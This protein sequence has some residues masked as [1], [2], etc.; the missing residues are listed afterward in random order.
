MATKEE[1]NA[2]LEGIR[3]QTGLD[4]MVP[5]GFGMVNLHVQDEYDAHL[6]FI[7]KTGKILC[8]V[9]LMALTKDAGKEV[10][11]DL[12]AGGLFGVDTAG[13]YFSLETASE[14]V[15]YNY[16]FDFDKVA[17]S[18]EVFIETFENIIALMD[19]WK[20]RIQ[21]KLTSQGDSSG[22]LLSDNSF[23]AGGNG[24]IIQP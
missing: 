19:V 15:I 18:P 4:M 8:F 14:T 21:E 3:K 12:L 6:Q 11:R 5:D 7:E 2:F 13:G 20:T 22:E 23:Q 1:Y 17:A 9:E 16:L 24:F 10:Y